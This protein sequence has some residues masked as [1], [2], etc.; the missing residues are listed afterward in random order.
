MTCSFEGVDIALFSAGGGISKKY[1]PIASE[2]GCT[3]RA[4]IIALADGH[5]F[6]VILELL[7]SSI[8]FNWGITRTSCIYF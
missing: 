2:M 5:D 4:V 7:W 1:A 3:V 6:A 8:S